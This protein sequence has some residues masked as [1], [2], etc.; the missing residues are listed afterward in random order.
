CPFGKVSAIAVVIRIVHITTVVA[1]PPYSPDLNPIKHAWIE[2]KKCLYQQYPRIG[3]TA[4]G[5]ETVK[6]ML[7][8]I[9]PLVW[10]TISEEFLKKLW[11]LMPDKVAAVLE[12]RGGYTKY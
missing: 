2:L 4:G 12:A 8:N 3:D 5:K 1:E 7:A 10:K 6:K 9:L 11:K